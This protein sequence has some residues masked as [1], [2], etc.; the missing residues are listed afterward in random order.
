MQLTDIESSRLIPADPRRFLDE[1]FGG[2]QGHRK[3]IPRSKDRRLS[4][5]LIGAGPSFA[6]S[7]WAHTL[8]PGNPRVMRAIQVRMAVWV[9]MRRA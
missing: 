3:A 9:S 6:G 4:C 5:G 1:G 2:D 8:K 7:T